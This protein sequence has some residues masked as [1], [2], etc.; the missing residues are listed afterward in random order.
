MAARPEDWLKLAEAID[1]PTDANRHEIAQRI[2]Y[3]AHPEWHAPTDDELEFY[4][5]YGER[6]ALPRGPFLADL[7]ARLERE[8]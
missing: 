6:L 5:R 3:M 2:R 7:R 1:S 8:R 4:A